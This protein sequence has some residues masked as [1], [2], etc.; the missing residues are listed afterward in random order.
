M[1]M[2][3]LKLTAR[4][5]EFDT[6]IANTRCTNIYG[7]NEDTEES[8]EHLVKLMVSNN[9]KGGTIYLVGNGGSAAVASH[10]LTDFVNA[11]HLRSFTLHESSLITCM[12]NDFGYEEAFKRILKSVM[13][14]YDMLIA[15]SSSGKSPNIHNAVDMAK[16]KGCHVVTLS[17]FQ[18][19]NKLSKMGNLNFWL[20]SSDYGLVEIGHLF[21]LHNVADRIAINVDKGKKLEYGDEIKITANA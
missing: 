1:T 5:T 6:L 10:A 16:N 7:E 19:D 18:P 17:G 11:C 3:N 8:M 4:G 12:A 20:D 15:I 14:E 21:I 13:C 9:E 2:K